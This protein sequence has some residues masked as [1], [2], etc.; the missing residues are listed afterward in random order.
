[1]TVWK[2]AIYN[3]CN[4][5]LCQPKGRDV[6]LTRFRLKPAILVFYLA[7]AIEEACSDVRP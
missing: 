7:V 3:K 5:L 4:I 2:G 6:F 1:M